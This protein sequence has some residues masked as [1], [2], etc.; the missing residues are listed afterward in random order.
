MQTSSTAMAQALLSSYAST[1]KN[2]HQAKFETAHTAFPCCIVTTL[3]A[4]TRFQH[5][6]WKTNSRLDLLSRLGFPG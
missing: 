1:C 3:G 5:L 6:I 4:H 2:T